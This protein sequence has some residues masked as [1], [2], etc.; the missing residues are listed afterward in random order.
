[1]RKI[2]YYLTKL[3]KKSLYDP[4]LQTLEIDNPK[5]QFEKV[6]E[7]LTLLPIGNKEALNKFFS[8]LKKISD[9]CEVNKMGVPNLG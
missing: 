4:L 7:L 6:S 3:K 5:E 2:F 9:N 1:M 8:L